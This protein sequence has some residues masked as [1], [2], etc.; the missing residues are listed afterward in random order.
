M[1]AYQFFLKIEIY[2]S[3]ASHAI[4]IGSSVAACLLLDKKSLALLQIKS[5][6]FPPVMSGNSRGK[7]DR[8]NCIET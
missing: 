4:F 6:I 2:L 8:V 3:W 7:Y 1:V 5:T